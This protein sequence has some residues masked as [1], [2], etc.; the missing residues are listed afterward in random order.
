LGIPADNTFKEEATMKRLSGLDAA[1]LSGETTT[2]H[3][4]VCGVF[5]FDTSTVPGG[6]SFGRI[7][8]LIQNRL[9]LLPPFRRR[10]VNVPFGLHLPIWIEDPDFD[11][12]YHIRRASLP[13][14]GSDKELQE[15]AAQVVEQPLDLTKPLWEMYVVEG[16]QDNMIALIT[17]TH[18]AAID[19][20]SGAELAA[21]ILDLSNE[22]RI[23]P[24]E[25]PPWK[26]DRVPNDLELIAYGVSSLL[27]HPP[28]LLKLGKDTI[29]A[30]INVA[31]RNRSLS[32]APPPAP[33]K[34][35]KVKFNG[36]ISPHRKVAFAQVSLDNVKFVK[37]TFGG[38][39]N[40]VILTICGSALRTYLLKHKDLP[41]EPLV[42]MIPISVR[43]ESERGT[44]GN[45][46][47]MML[48]SLE[49][50][51]TDP[52]QRLKSISEKTRHAKE[53]HNAIGADVLTNWFEFAAPAV[54][55]RA[56]RLISSTK[57]FN[58]L[59]PAFNVTISNVPGPNFALYSAGARMVAMYPLGPIVEGVGLNIT[60]MSYIGTMFIGIQADRALVPD[61]ELIAAF[62]EESLIDLVKAAERKQRGLPA[63]ARSYPRPKRP[64][65]KSAIA[66]KETKRKKA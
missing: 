2:M 3:N 31:Q 11:L 41:E 4:H 14:P 36:A 44:L 65:I 48:V 57:L 54:F 45:K 32:V 28:S 23:L 59:K 22:I 40:D 9:Q 49:T 55:A 25:S 27:K 64:G 33:F 21:Q 7:K 35:P 43:S 50:N 1:F 30:V 37:N 13:A 16:L 47:S 10:I 53:Q 26:P 6:Y 61:V 51:V 60:I 24:E 62:L 12:D 39:V 5:V 34:A 38:T 17:K 58:R 46:V 15:F 19:G 56:A 66:I 29:E 52:I 63:R 20:V 42:A 18:H 8:D